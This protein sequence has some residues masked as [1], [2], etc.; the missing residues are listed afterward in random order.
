M[1]P[2]R[3][4]GSADLAAAFRA[5]HF[6]Y[7][8]PRVFEDSLALALIGMRWRVACRTGALQWITRRFGG[9]LRRSVAEVVGRSR[10]AEDQL[11]AAVATGVR[12]YVILGAGMDS[13]AYRR[14]GREAAVR[15]YELDHPATQA[16]KRDRLSKA[17]LG[18]PPQLEFVPVNFEHETVREALTRSSYCQDDPAL[19]SWLGTTMYLSH[20]AIVSTLT[21]I[22]A[23]AARESRVVF[24]YRV[25][26]DLMDPADRSVVG[27]GDR[28]AQRNGEP[29]VPFVRPEHLAGVVGEVEFDIVENLSPRE[30]EA[31]YF[32]GRTDDLRPISHMYFAQLRRR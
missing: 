15:V 10:Y 18:V 24:D 25:P 32:R 4:S 9:G 20:D 30:Q 16:R 29:Q 3:A 2:D 31:R 27:R 13:F 17:R 5:T 1:R 28:M 8:R 7:D 22:A 21:S 23:C 6:L 12:Q 11:E 19:F 26:D 14:S